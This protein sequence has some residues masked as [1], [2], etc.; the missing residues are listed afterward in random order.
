MSAPP[1]PT[2]PDW[3]IS[4]LSKVD[5][6]HT[7]LLVIDVQKDFCSEGGAL[8]AL[9]SDVSPCRAVAAR[10]ADFLPAVRGT[11]SFVAFFQLIYDIEKMSE[12]QRE[13]LLRDGKPVICA[14]G[15]PGAELFIAPAPKDLVFIKH[16]YSAFSNQ[17]FCNLLQERSIT[18]VVVTGVDTQICVEGA[19]RHGYD[20]GY[21]MLVLSDLVATRRSEINR[22]ENSL[23]LCERYFALTVDSGTFLQLLRTRSSSSGERT[24]T[25]REQ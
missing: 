14:P 4:V 17:R 9:G 16:R 18:T 1:K 23:V 11:V 20:L 24:A 2:S 21:R 3:K 12:A 13:R 15:S 22:H 10:I 19:V 25:R 7:A 6:R 5:P 8:A